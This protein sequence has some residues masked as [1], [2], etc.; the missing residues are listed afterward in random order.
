MQWE[1]GISIIGAWWLES[2][3]RR[4]FF[5]FCFQTIY[6]SDGAWI[7]DQFLCDVL[8]KKISHQRIQFFIVAW[9]HREG[10]GCLFPGLS[11]DLIFLCGLAGKFGERRL[12][13]EMLW[14]YFIHCSMGMKEWWQEIFFLVF[15]VWIYCL[16]LVIYVL[17]NLVIC[18]ISWLSSDFYTKYDSSL[19][20]IFSFKGNIFIWFLQQ[21]FKGI[22]TTILIF[23]YHRI[24]TTNHVVL[25]FFL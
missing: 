12:E 7:W 25:Q 24:I 23:Y 9:K 4:Y 22:H 3:F 13:P 6:L 10:S 15:L 8:L 11:T 1:N 14:W 20:L 2:G 16:F 21:Q 18:K 17:T 19:F 5:E